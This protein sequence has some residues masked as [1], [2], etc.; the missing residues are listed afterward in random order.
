MLPSSSSVSQIQQF[1]R[2]QQGVIEVARTSP[3]QL[4]LTVGERV[5]ATVTGQLPNG[6]FAVLVKDQ[7]LDLNLPS[8]TQPGE[9]LELVVASKDP[10]LTFVLAQ[11][12]PQAQGTPLKGEVA[13][14]QTAKL[15]GELVP[16]QEGGLARPATLLQ[17]EPLFEGVP[18][19]DKL[20][21]TLASR[22]AESGLFYESHQAE[23]VNGERQLA[24]LLKEP[25]AK[26][27]TDSRPLQANVAT[28]NQ[29]DAE[30]NT[31]LAGKTSLAQASLSLPESAA[32]NESIQ[33]A[34]ARAMAEIGQAKGAEQHVK[35]LVQQQLALLENNPLLWQGQAW[36]GQELTWQT[37]LK[38]EGERLSYEY[39]QNKVWQTRLDLS[40]PHMGEIG[41][42]TIFREGK[43][44][45]RFEVAKEE[46]SQLVKQHQMLLAE[47]FALAGLTI[48]AT[49]VFMSLDEKDT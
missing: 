48:S 41:V 2:A 28:P 14:S 3:D 11:N 17:A 43:F 34:V 33:Q 37:E 32:K 18:Q 5:Q 26:L 9:Q 42:V 20:A 10:K 4:L 16:K 44:E 12:N 38:N 49:Q 35:H 19:T 15:L 31:L 29:V 27:A 36:P 24:A 39:E 40:L 46:T 45:L 6:R 7:L 30:E 23:W 8:N 21:A 47:R 13:F 25:Q 1:V 22:L